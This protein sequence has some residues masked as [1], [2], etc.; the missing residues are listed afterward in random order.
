[1]ADESILLISCCSI[2]ELHTSRADG[3]RC[4]WIDMLDALH[5]SDFRWLDDVRCFDV[6]GHVFGL[7]SPSLSLH[8]MAL[9]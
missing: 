4:R 7:I 5:M 8:D 6:Y 3:N 1:M 9:A 2:S